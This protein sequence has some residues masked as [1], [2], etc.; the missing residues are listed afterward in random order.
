MPAVE[1]Q[2]QRNLR[3]V[4]IAAC[5]ERGLCDMQRALLMGPRT[6]WPRLGLAVAIGIGLALMAASMW[7]G[8]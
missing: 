4:F 6:P 2:A 7:I 5:R 3:A 1:T 8:G